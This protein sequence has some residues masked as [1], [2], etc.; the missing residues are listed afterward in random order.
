[1]LTLVRDD[2]T[3]TRKCDYRKGKYVHM[4]LEER[5]WEEVDKREENECWNWLGNIMENGYGRAYYNS[6]QLKVHRL[7]WTI[8]YGDIP[9]GKEVC[10]TCDNKRCVNPKHLFLGTQ[11]DNMKD[12]NNKNRQAVGESHGM[13]KLTNEIVREMRKKY[14][15]NKN[16]TID[17]LAKKYCLDRH[18]IGLVINNKIWIDESYIPCVRC[19]R[20][21]SHRVKLTYKDITE[22][23]N[24]YNETK[25]KQSELANEYGV[26]QRYI[27]L[28]FRNEIWIDTERRISNETGR[29]T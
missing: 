27:S 3:L 16:L 13:S 7:S 26:S 22:I 6:E 21:G 9:E 24:K 20:E 17:K 19:G 14:S 23:R 29:F 15:N 18:T 28:I 25:M 12:R 5:F 8:H 2:D 1:M 10:H 11:K 4:S